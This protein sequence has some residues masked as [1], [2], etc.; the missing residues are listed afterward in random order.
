MSTGKSWRVDR[1]ELENY[2]C[3]TEFSIDFDD[4]F[5][6]LVGINGAGKSAV[7]DALAVMLSTVIY[8][9]GDSRRGFNSGD[10]RLVTTL[11]SGSSVS[12]MESVFPISGTVNATLAG[13][14]YWWRRSKSSKSGRTGWGDKRLIDKHVSN[15]W[16]AASSDVP[17]AK[18]PVIAMYGVER[19]VGVRRAQGKIRRSRRDAYSASLDGKSDLT[20]LSTYIQGLTLDEY[21]ASAEL[22]VS[23]SP[24]SRQL[25]AIRLACERVLESSGWTG[26]YWR[27]N[28]SELTM[29]HTDHGELPLSSL[30]SGLKITAGLAL[31]LASRMARANPA[32]GGE[33][34]LETVPGIVLIDEI[35]L[36]LHPAWQQRIVPSLRSA[37]PEV[38]FIVTTHSPQVLST[39]PAEGVRILE[40]EKV[41]RVQHSEGLRSDVLLRKIFGTEPQPELEVTERLRSYLRFVDAGLGLQDQARELRRDLD[42]ILGGAQLVPALA[43]ADAAMTFYDLDDE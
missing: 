19:L 29:V 39:V 43:D 21:T 5:T 32:L 42:N 35:D 11:G 3:F 7:L 14:P 30:S 28:I 13:E 36:H 4:S 18:L 10:G 16:N 33:E 34:L 8:E 6:V 25:A 38:Q 26:P 2:R 41:E 1:L 23:D 24:E 15:I 17:T 9:L 22:G 12:T 20:R 27:Q 37:F 40:S 31:D